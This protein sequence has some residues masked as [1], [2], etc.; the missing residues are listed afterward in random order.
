MGTNNVV[1]RRGNVVRKWLAENSGQLYNFPTYKY[2]SF[3]LQMR[4]YLVR[5]G[6]SVYRGDKKAP[7]CEN[8][9]GGSDW[10]MGAPDT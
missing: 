7:F 5:G 1:G 3:T 2:Y 4:T 8:W 9:R 6:I 10:W